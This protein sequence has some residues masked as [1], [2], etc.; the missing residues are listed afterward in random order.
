MV[1]ESLRGDRVVGIALDITTLFTHS[2]Q[3]WVI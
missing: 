1:K 3:G 2:S